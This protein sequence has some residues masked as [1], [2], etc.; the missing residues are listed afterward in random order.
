MLHKEVGT[1]RAPIYKGVRTVLGTTKFVDATSSEYD[2]LVK[3]ERI[4]VKDVEG[5]VGVTTYLYG[6]IT[7]C[8]HD[9]MLPGVKVAELS[10][11]MF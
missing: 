5:G 6:W 2:A 1:I 11:T 8:Y 3:P 10:F 9:D 7:M 4:I